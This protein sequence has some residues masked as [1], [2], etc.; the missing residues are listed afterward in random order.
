MT[1]LTLGDYPLPADACAIYLADDS[2][3]RLVMPGYRG[4][5][6]SVALPTGEAGLRLLT[7]ILRERMAAPKESQRIAMGMQAPTS[8][9][10]EQWLK[11][12]A[13]VKPTS[14]AGVGPARKYEPTPSEIDE[15]L[16]GIEL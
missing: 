1:T 10:C 6:H 15:L 9:M 5:G 7:T 13:P 12:H 14:P 16:E 8:V 2:T 4:E 11:T 3:L